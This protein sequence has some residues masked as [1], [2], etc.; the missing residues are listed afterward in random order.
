ML[1]RR[2]LF[3]LSV[4]TATM[5]GVV[6]AEPAMAEDVITSSFD[7]QV[8]HPGETVTLTVTFKNPETVDVTFTYLTVNPTYDTTTDKTK[9]TMGACAGEI[10]SCNYFTT[11]IPP[12]GTRTMT[13]PVTIAADSPCGQN[14]N[15][16]FYFY[17]YRE[18]AAGSFDGI[19]GGGAPVTVQC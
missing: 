1:V 5:L 19:V 12:G 7:K 9:Y 15:V 16:G 17:S 8:A 13:Q 10:T 18:S 6:F 4:V 14:I 11:P 3:V 2:I